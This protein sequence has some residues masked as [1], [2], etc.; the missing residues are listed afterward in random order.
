MALSLA[1]LIQGGIVMYALTKSEVSK[2]KK[3]GFDIYRTRSMN[4][5]SDDTQNIIK[6]ITFSDSTAPVGSFKYKVHRYP[7]DIDIFEPVKIC[8]TREKAIGSISKEL[9]SIATKVKNSK[10]VFWGDFKAGLDFIYKP[11]TGESHSQYED[12]TGLK[13]N[14]STGDD[15]H[16]AARKYY[17]VRWTVDEVVRGTK[18]LLSGTALTLEEAITHDTLIKLDLWGKVD[19]NYTEITNFFVFAWTD[20]NED[21]VLN[22]DL[23]DRLESLNSDIKKYSSPDHWNPLKLAKRLWNKALYIK[24]DKLTHKLY[25]LFSSGA[26]ILNQVV[27]E[28]E[29]LRFMYEKI[30]DNKLPKKVMDKQIEG[31]K[32]R[33]NDV[34]EIV[35]DASVYDLIDSI[36]KNNINKK[37]M[38]LK[39]LEDMLTGLVTKYT[40]NWLSQANVI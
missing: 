16:E 28:A 32:R 37:I 25:P 4:G 11:I 39:E 15:W 27:G 26:A 1:Q 18:V 38:L 10:T 21:H 19:G 29:T 12:R 7:G 24:D 33:I 6:L 17:V 20:G 3:N 34:A 23:E 5:L 8:C 35:V 14:L 9:K 31:F 40:E 13:L 2:G 22:A 30:P 36:V